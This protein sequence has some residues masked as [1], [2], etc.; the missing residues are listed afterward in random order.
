MRTKFCDWCGQQITSSSLP[1]ISVA[2]TAPTPMT[3]PDL[4]S[5][6]C[7]AAWLQSRADQDTSNGVTGELTTATEPTTI[8]VSPAASAQAGVTSTAK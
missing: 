8:T 1:Q 3:S 4:C 7:A 2:V 5:Y 6:A